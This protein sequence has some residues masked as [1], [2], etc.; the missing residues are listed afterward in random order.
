MPRK[1]AVVGD[2]ARPPRRASPKTI[3][4]AAR[5][6]ER[7]LLVALRTYLASHMDAGAVP[8]HALASVSGKIRE[9]DR[10]IR[11]LDARDEQEAKAPADEPFDRSEV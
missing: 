2:Q 10:D 3:T 5:S 9:Y 11:T 7:D 6:S 1:L 8:A 4:R